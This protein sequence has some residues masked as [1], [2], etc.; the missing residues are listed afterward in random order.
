[1]CTLIKSMKLSTKD[2]ILKEIQAVIRNLDNIPPPPTSLST[3]HESTRKPTDEEKKYWVR[4]VKY[5]SEAINV[6]ISIRHLSPSQQAEVYHDPMYKSLATKMNEK[7]T[8]YSA[9]LQEKMYSMLQ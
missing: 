6:L 9:V 8:P 2:S 1:M 4:R 3:I 5:M 7:E